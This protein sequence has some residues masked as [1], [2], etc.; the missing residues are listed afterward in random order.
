V[1]RVAKIYSSPEWRRLR[2]FVLERDGHRCTVCD[3]PVF[4]KGE[5]RVDHIRRVGD[6]GPVWD[7]AN[8]RTLCTTCDAQAHRE[9]GSGAL[10]RQERFELRGCNAAGIPSGRMS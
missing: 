7:P 4:G 5:A 2:E 1:K 3:I 9:K 6:G 8:C 10:Y